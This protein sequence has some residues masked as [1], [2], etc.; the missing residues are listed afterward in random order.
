MR[1]QFF[2]GIGYVYPI[3]IFDYR[4]FR[5]LAEKYIV[6]GANTLHN[7]YK[8][9]KNVNE[10]DYFVETSIQNK[11]EISYLE[12][13]LSLTP[14]N[15]EDTKRQEQLNEIYNEYLKNKDM[16]NKIE[17][18]EELFSMILKRKVKFMLKSEKPLDY[19]FQ[20]EN[21]NN[22]ITNR[23]YK[24]FRQL[25]MW[26]NILFEIPTSPSE[27]G[28]RLIQQT[29]EV[30]FGKG[31][32]SSLSSICSVV[33]TKSGISD[34]QL[35]KYTYYRLMYDFAIINRLHGN[36]FVFMLRS[37]GCAEAV[38]SDLSQPVDLHKNPYDVIFRRHKHEQGN[39]K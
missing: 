16:I 38:I 28:N 12:Q 37:Q 39:V 2:N 10:L 31:E 35:Q 9:S 27:E 18:L 20:I 32:G 33:S 21:E 1:P 3:S 24:R 5:Q 22:F 17:E 7:I 6:K 23:N 36:M 11:R 8:T 34:E 25:V 13:A 4:R 19:C 14:D 26:Q 29:I 30:E 15:D